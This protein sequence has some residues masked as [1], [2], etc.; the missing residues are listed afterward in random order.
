MF[1]Y[2]VLLASINTEGGG[3]AWSFGCYA[4]SEE[5]TQLWETGVDESSRNIIQNTVRVYT[6]QCRARR[7]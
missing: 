4:Q 1:K 5:S 6:A 7:S 2:N 3:V